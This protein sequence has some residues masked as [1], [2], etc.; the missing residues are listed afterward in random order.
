MKLAV[1]NVSSLS[2]ED[3]RPVARA[4]HDQVVE[5]FIPSIGGQSLGWGSYADVRLVTRETASFHAD[6]I[7][8]LADDTD[9]PGILGYHDIDAAGK[10]Y[11]YVFRALSDALGEPWSVT[12]SHEVLELVQD[13]TANAFCMGPHPRR[14]TGV[15]LHWLEVCDAVQAQSYE[16]RGVQ[17]S[18]F[19]LPHYFTRREEPG[20]RTN[21]LG[22]P[23]RSFGV[24]PGGYVGFYDPLTGQDDQV[25]ADAQAERRDRAKQRFAAG[26]R[27]SRRAVR[28]H[29]AAA[30]GWPMPEALR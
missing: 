27:A 9:Q 5:D 25:F 30:H 13:P 3:V 18:N 19:V 24:A 20:M 10:P 29:L 1:V 8:Y 11:G 14:S 17:V 26:R 28:P 2:E 6:A 22:S 23:L 7:V 12:L 21:F 4:V 16:K 15:V